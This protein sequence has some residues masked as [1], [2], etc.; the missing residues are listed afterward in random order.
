MLLVPPLAV[1]VVNNAKLLDTYDLS[2]VDKVVIGAAPLSQETMD[3]L[4]DLL[5]NKMVSCTQGTR[6]RFTDVL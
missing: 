3:S 5:P 1:M 2:H 4:I 6:A